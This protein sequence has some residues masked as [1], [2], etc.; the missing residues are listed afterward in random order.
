MKRGHHAI[1][2]PLIILLGVLTVLGCVQ[3]RS[4]VEYAG[5]HPEFW[6]DPA[7][8]DFHGKKVVAVG[9]ASCR[10]CHGEDFGGGRSGISCFT[11]HEAYPHTDGWLVASSQDFH[12]VYIRGHGWNLVI[13]Q[14]CHGEDYDG[15]EGGRSC[16]ACHSG[17][18]EACN[19]C[20]GSGSNPAPPEAID[21]DTA[22]TFTGVGAHQSHISYSSVRFDCSECHLKPDS[23]YQ[24]G[25]VDSDLPAELSFGPLARAEGA[26]P[27]WDGAT[28]ADVY[29]HG[30]TVSGPNPDP[31]WTVVD[32]SQAACG[33]CHRIPPH[34]NWGSCDGCHPS[35]V[36][37]D[38]SII[39]RDLHV[40][41][42]LDF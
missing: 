31:V 38:T 5:V 36:G 21:G 25:H 9:L 3:E 20:H 32:G 28:C 19:T 26:D 40:N 10:E 8:G 29:C 1:S 14:T 4:P 23:L 15:G 12:G 35:V 34:G 33:A 2:G 16:N 22:T 11:C 41:G 27:L 37:P 18:P 7:S 13:C 30:S 6:T 39:D 17:T 24:P 42:L